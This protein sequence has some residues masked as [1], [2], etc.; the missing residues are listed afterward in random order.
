[1]HQRCQAKN[2][3]V[4]GFMGWFVLKLVCWNTHMLFVLP[5]SPNIILILTKDNVL[6]KRGT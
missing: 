6:L 1:M 5:R 2:R 3:F 4:V